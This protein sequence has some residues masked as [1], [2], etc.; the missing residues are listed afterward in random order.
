MCFIFF[1]VSSTSGVA[2]ETLYT[3]IAS[4]DWNLGKTR[5]GQSILPGTFEER[6]SVKKKIEAWRRD[7]ALLHANLRTP[8]CR[9]SWRR[10]ELNAHTTCT[11][12]Y[13]LQPAPTVATG[14]CYHATLTM[15]FRVRHHLFCRWS[16]CCWTAD[17]TQ[18]NPG[19]LR[20]LRISCRRRFFHSENLKN[21]TGHLTPGRWT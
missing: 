20:I 19:L 2:M 12:S 17:D 8:S 4:S 15:P 14:I 16:R 7:C 9:S 18:P 21:P 10:A 5:F 6:L 1:P 13:T 3:V 11:S